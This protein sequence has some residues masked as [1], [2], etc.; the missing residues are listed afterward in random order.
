[1]QL[2]ELVFD[3]TDEIFITED[4]VFEMAR[5]KPNRSGVPWIIFISSKD[6]VKQKHWARVKISNVK[7]TFS[8]NDNFVVSISKQPK[9][10][11]GKAKM[12]QAE[13]EDIFDWVILN[14]D[15]L[16]KYWNEQYE[17]EAEMYQQLRK[18]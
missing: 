10:L 13:L 16:I 9:V 5:V 6:Y 1:M 15:V 11:A 8:E 4:Q 17:D 12:K 3:T 14:Y 18:I 7:G 2:T